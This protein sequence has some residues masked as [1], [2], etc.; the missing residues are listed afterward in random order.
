MFF[1]YNFELNKVSKLTDMNKSKYYAACTV[2]EGKIVVTGGKKYLPLNHAYIS[3]EAYDDYENKWTYLPNMIR[4]RRLHAS[5]SMGNKLFVI[6]GNITKSCEVFDSF[7]R[8]FTLIKA[9]TPNYENNWLTQFQ[10]VSKSNFI[11]FI[12]ENKNSND[13]SMFIYNVQKS[14]WSEKK[15]SVLNKLTDVSCAKYC[16][17]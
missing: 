6:G 13:T 17:D 2:F 4:K 16:T 12:S 1:Y 8:K 11:L 10:A 5:V 3:V 9:K 15:L 14:Q 7:T